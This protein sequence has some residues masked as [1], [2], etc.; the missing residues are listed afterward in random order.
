MA[1]SKHSR[2]NVIFLYKTPLINWEL[3]YWSA[4]Y[5][6]PDLGFHSLFQ[7]FVGLRFYVFAGLFDEAPILFYNLH[8]TQIHSLTN[9]IWKMATFL[10]ACSFMQC[11]LYMFLIT[12]FSCGPLLCYIWHMCEKNDVQ[13]YN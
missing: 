5:Q 10:P 3:T 9:I 4:L 13:S 1:L 12:I 6:T 2:V 11:N 7:H 8:S